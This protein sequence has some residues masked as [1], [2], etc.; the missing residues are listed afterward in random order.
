M[1]PWCGRHRLVGMRGV[2]WL[3]AVLVLA[4]GCGGAGEGPG[5]PAIGVRVGVGLTVPP[6]A[7]ISRAT[8]EACWHGRCVTRP[9]DL[10]PGTAAGSTTCATGVCSAQ[11]TATGGLQGFVDLPGLPAEPIRVTVRFDDGRPH[12]TDVTPAWVEPGGPAC[13]QA[14]PQA[15]LVVG[16][17]REIRPK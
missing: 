12:T 3:V 15:Q 13:G 9:A 8:L 5:C 17:D 1:Q 16:A 11:Q 4:A 2:L 6:A 10:M 14:G 7:G